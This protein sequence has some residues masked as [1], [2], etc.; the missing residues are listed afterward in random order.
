MSSDGVF[1]FYKLVDWPHP[2]T[3][4]TSG[5]AHE[6]YGETRIIL[7]NSLLYL[8]CLIKTGLESSDL[9]WEEPV[10]RFYD[11]ILL[12]LETRSVD[13]ESTHQEVIALGPNHPLC[14]H[15]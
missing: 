14:K 15:K 3:R 9:V 7:H 8:V 6:I 2:I 10:P 13:F 5:W 4:D 1:D 11:E 12:F